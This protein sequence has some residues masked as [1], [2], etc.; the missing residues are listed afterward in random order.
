MEGIE[1]HLE[2]NNG[3][4]YKI[5]QKA[6]KKL[7]K[8][9]HGAFDKTELVEIIYVFKVS[10]EEDNHSHGCRVK[11]KQ[12]ESVHVEDWHSDSFHNKES[13]TKVEE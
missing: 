7:A 9:L 8:E 1:T 13:W 6:N 12:D 10:R 5:G 4:Y 11:V 2:R 3:K